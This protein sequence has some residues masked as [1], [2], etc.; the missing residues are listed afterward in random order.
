MYNLVNE[1]NY[2]NLHAC[3]CRNHSSFDHI[4]IVTSWEID[5]INNYPEVDG[6]SCEIFCSAATILVLIAMPPI[7]KDKV[8]FISNNNIKR[9][10]IHYNTICI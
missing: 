3:L 10:T 1:S 4:M 8:K 5:E 9:N 6:I 2:K 7:R